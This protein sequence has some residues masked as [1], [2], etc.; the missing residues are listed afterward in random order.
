MVVK[1]EKVLKYLEENKILDVDIPDT[2]RYIIDVENLIY[3]I[4]QGEFD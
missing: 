2:E 4:K 3:L 1:K